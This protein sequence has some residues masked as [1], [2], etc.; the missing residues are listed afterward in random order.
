MR[1]KS[2][3]IFKLWI[4]CQFQLYARCQLRC[5]ETEITAI[6]CL[7]KIHR[8]SQTCRLKFDCSTPARPWCAMES[9]TRRRILALIAARQSKRI[10]SLIRRDSQCLWIQRRGARARAPRLIF[11][12]NITHCQHISGGASHRAREV[13]AV[14][15]AICICWRC[16]WRAPS[17]YSQGW[18]HMVHV[19]SLLVT[20]NWTVVRCDHFCDSFL[21]MRWAA[22]QYILKA[23]Y[24]RHALEKLKGGWVWYLLI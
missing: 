8:A 6:E 21:Y 13:H 11:D 17:N 19:S 14:D 10:S 18:D 3:W 7:F 1:A 22:M 16:N 2:I 20:Q 15:S 9:S 5:V 12:N 24:S 4:N 23:I